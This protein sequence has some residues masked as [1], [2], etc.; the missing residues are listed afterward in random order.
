MPT[1]FLALG[2]NLAD[3]RRL[4]ADALAALARHPQNRLTAVSPV[5]ETRAVRLPGQDEQPDY[6]NL[7]VQLETSLPPHAL[8]D[9]CLATE[10]DLGRIRRERWGPRTVDLDVLLH[11]ETIL[12]D[13]RLT[14]PHPRMKERAFVLV[15]LA[16]LAPD[17]LLDGEPV[18]ARLARLGTDGV[19]RTDTPLTLPPA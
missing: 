11:G 15:P 18:R 17:L 6:L 1:A 8:L 3:R 4:L 7:V 2:S 12:D 5:Y 10:H 16:D 13:E 9:L 14:L 19:R